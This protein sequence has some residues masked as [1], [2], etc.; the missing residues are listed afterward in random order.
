MGS[1]AL[2][3]RASPLRSICFMEAFTNDVAGMP[4]SAAK[5]LS[6]RLVVSSSRMFIETVLLMLQLY[7]YCIHNAMLFTSRLM[8]CIRL[9]LA[10][11]WYDLPMRIEF[12]KHS[13]DQLKVRPRITKNMIISAVPSL[14]R[15]WTLTEGEN[16]TARLLRRTC[17]R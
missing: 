5:S 14:N 9:Y 3:K 6:S 16:S 7:A 1:R 10:F 12:S 13:L 8:L 4:T 11:T 2:V 17:L 15:F